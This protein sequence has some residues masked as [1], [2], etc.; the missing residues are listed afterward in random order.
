MVGT[1][2]DSNFFTLFTFIKCVETIR[3]EVFI[4]FAKADM[5]PE[6]IATDFAF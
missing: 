1:V 5:K 6:N 3:E 2:I 4:G